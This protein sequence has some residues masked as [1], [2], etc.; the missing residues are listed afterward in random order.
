MCPGQG[1]GASHGVG[2]MSFDFI[3]SLPLLQLGWM[4]ASGDG[5]GSTAGEGFC[6]EEIDF[7]M[8]GR[9]VMYL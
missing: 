6:R 7:R 4:R 2:R 1:R 8:E 5:G 9:G 3:R